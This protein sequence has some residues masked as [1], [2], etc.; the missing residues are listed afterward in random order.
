MRSIPR[1]AVGAA[2]VAA[3]LLALAASSRAF[4]Q[5]DVLPPIPK[6]DISIGLRPVATGLG[7]R[8]EATIRELEQAARRLAR[9]PVSRLTRKNPP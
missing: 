7:A 9:G 3:A 8:G 4:G 5:A 2:H 6:G 1:R